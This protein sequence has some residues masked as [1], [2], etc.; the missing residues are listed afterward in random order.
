MALFLKDQWKDWAR[1]WGLA[2]RPEKGWL[3]RNER[4]LGSHK[5]L[6]FHVGWGADQSPGLIVTV[7]FPRVS[8]PARVRQ[9]LIDDS[10]LDTLPG[11]GAARRKMALDSGAKN[12]IRIGYEE[13]TLMPD[14]LLWRRSFA[15]KAP[16]PPQVQEW[17]DTL[18]LAIG[19]ATGPFDGRCETCGTGVAR[20]YVVVDDLPV[21][22]CASCQQKL[23]AE[24]DMAERTYDMIEINHLQGAMLGL[25]ASAGGAIVWA[26]LAALTH[27]IFS[28]VAIGIGALV[29]WAYRHGAGRVDLAGRAIAV[30]LTLLSVTV[31]DILLYA[32]WVAQAHP[33]VGFRLDAG[34]VAYLLTWA[35]SPRDEISTLVF[36]LAGAW[37]A[38]SVLQRPR[39]A[40]RIETAEGRGEERKAA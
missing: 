31:G 1:A 25:A 3:Y 9:A 23:K 19:R 36:G 11:K 15:F 12:V 39:I 35:E 20:N 40:A 17:V 5:G 6:L 24:G 26:G 22:M 21:M 14:R 8:D 27:R 29:A 13:F 10:S 28:L 33:E 16:K 32:F 4:V 38:I 7:R 34:W 2:H 30:A 18:V 37:V